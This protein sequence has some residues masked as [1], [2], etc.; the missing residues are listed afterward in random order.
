MEAAT[1]L[2]EPRDL[3]MDNDKRT[4]L[5][6]DQI[7]LLMHDAER[8][9]D[10][11]YAQANK[12]RN[13]SRLTNLA[14]LMLSLAAAAGL[15]GSLQYETLIAA[16]LSITL[17]ILLFFTVAS[18]TFVEIVFGFSRNAGVAEVASRQAEDIAFESRKLHRRISSTGSD[19]D[20]VATADMLQGLLNAVTRVGLPHD[21]K[22]HEKSARD[23]TKLLNVE[24]PEGRPAANSQ[25][26]PSPERAPAET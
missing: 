23:A 24:F 18:L 14:L 6:R 19:Y 25:P 4:A 8:L 16:L 1:R 13:F 5:A 11:Y 9:H 12:Y 17:S 7:W 22:L 26:D 2:T 10:Y 3:L 21:E 20:V 15:L